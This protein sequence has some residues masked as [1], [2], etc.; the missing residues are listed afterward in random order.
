MFFS[1]SVG[2][3]EI[4][5]W[6]CAMKRLLLTAAIVVLVAASSWG[7]TNY[8]S[9]KSNVYAPFP[10][11]MITTAS[12]NFSAGEGGVVYTTPSNGDF[13]LTQFCAGPNAFGGVQLEAANF[14]TIAET[15]N[16]A[17]CYTFTPGVSIPPNSELTCSTAGFHKTTYFCTISGIQTTPSSPTPTA[18]ATV[19]P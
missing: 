10:N 16:G 19:L 6:R 17:A 9:S 2:I 11:A 13:I 12:I 1:G 7:S 8:N 14:G 18:T 15:E 4:P 3:M 5:A